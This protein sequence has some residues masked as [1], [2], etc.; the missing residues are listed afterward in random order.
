M[1]AYVGQTRA[2][3]II[4]GLRR[5]GIGECTLRGELPPRRA[6]YFYD[7]G[8]YTDHVSGSQFNVNQFMRDIR[9]MRQ[10]G[11]GKASFERPA[12]IVL[13]DLVARGLESLA[14]SESWIEECVDV[15]PL[16]LAVQNGMSEGNIEALLARQ[17]GKI[18]GLF[19]G[20]TMDW[21]LGTAASW[22]VFAHARGLK[23]HIGRVGTLERVRWAKAIGADSI[24]SS[25]PL[26]TRDRLAEFI[27][28]VAA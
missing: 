4:D 1:R 12:F 11:K 10:R 15:A 21:K 6:D 28:E 25:F 14:E 26:W 8:A 9:A 2:K 13:P 24:D 5:A 19:I 20:G 18:A 7:N 23:V 22:I 3:D 17:P 27:L 16:Y